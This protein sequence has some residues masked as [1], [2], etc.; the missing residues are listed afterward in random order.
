MKNIILFVSIFV[1]ISSFTNAKVKPPD[2]EPI[3]HENIKY[4]TSHVGYVDAID[5]INGHKLWHRQIYVVMYEINRPRCS[6]E[7]FIRNMKIKN[8]NLII[9]N[10][11]YLNLK[12][13]KVTSLDDNYFEGKFK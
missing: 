1:S 6:Q 3:I 9:N 2:I 12:T 4:Q 5:M 13:L 8:N 10:K 11:Y 7:K